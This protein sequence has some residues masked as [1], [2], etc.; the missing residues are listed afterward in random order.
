[1]LKS[2]GVGQVGA[3][4]GEKRVGQYTPNFNS[5]WER[6]G[7]VVCKRNRVDI[8]LFYEI[9]SLWRLPVTEMTFIGHSRS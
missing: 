1:M 8:F 2:T 3:Q 4:F 5:I 6:H 7:D 9:I